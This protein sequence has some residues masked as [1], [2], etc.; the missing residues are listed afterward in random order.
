MKP[1]NGTKKMERKRKKKQEIKI[2][3]E[4]IRG[5]GEGRIENMGPCRS[6][7]PPKILNETPLME[8]QSSNNPNKQPRRLN[9]FKK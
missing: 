9:Q 4:E 1:R 8:V 3:P 7:A 5:I 2:R 6:R